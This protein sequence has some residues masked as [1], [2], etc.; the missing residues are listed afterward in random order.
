MQG[1]LFKNTVWMAGGLG[2]KSLIQFIYFIVIARAL[3]SHGY[4]IFVALASLV[5]VFAP[6]SSW[7]SGNILI[8][9]VARDRALFS[10]Y[11]GSAIAITLYSS[12]T[13]MIFVGAIS[14]YVLP[15]GIPIILV[16]FVSLADL[17]FSRL[18][19]LSSQAF[20]AF[21]SLNISSII[22][23]LPNVFRLLA[24]VM[25]FFLPIAKN[26]LNWSV[27]YL[28]STFLSSLVAMILVYRN[29]GW[30]KL[31]VRPIFRELG[32][33]GAF[34]VSL[35]AQ[36]VYNDIDKSMLARLSSANAAGTYAAG[37]RIIDVAFT[38]VRSVLYASYAR[39]FKNGENGL[40]DSVRFAKKLL[41][42]S[43]LY[44]TCIMVVLYFSAPLIPVLFGIHFKDSIQVVRWLSPL[45]LLRSL[46]YFAADALTGA[47]Y[48]KLRT[49]VQTAVAGLNVVLNV[50]LL[51]TFGWI[52]AAWSSILCD[53]TLAI[54]LWLIIHLN[55]RRTENA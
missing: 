14:K 28:A 34:A 43:F 52:G 55:L 11:W 36:S 8:K 3:D 44:S 29:L 7:G 30:G 26:S 40:G 49:I 17:L 42:L 12:L 5:G 35:S 25:L 4:G 24:A 47:G 22:Q 53:A 6:F 1:R 48:Q 50:C 2:V 54:S 23:T 21:E 41:P 16:L 39:F 38:P 46:H 15:I 20:Q 18:T 37:S 51:P 45:I 27:L 13:L 33:A 32:E 9:H 19:D 31:D 10:N